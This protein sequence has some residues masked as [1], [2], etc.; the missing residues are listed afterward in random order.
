MV[1]EKPSDWIVH[2]CIK[3]SPD[4]L[5]VT[6]KRKRDSDLAPFAPFP[7]S[8]VQFML[9]TSPALKR[10]YSLISSV[11]KDQPEFIVKDVKGGK[12]SQYFHQQLKRGD[13][14]QIQGVHNSLWKDD[15]S[16]PGKT[17]ICFSGGIGVTPVYSLLHWGLVTAS[18]LN[19]SF[20]LFHSAKTP[21][22][23]LLT[24]ELNQ[25]QPNKRFNLMRVFSER[26][27][28][29]GDALGH[30]TK[31]NVLAWLEGHP[32]AHEAEFIICGPFG[33]MQNVHDA[34]DSL[35]VPAARRHTEYF[36]DRIIE[37]KLTRT[38]DAPVTCQDRPKCTV[39]IEQDSGVQQFKMH[40]EG[41]SILRAALQA[42][43]DVPHS[44][45]GGVCRS[46][47]AR[48]IE[49]EVL[50]DGVSGLSDSEK[51]E[52]KILCCRTQPKTNFLKL[53]FDH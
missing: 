39:E 4:S 25:L 6:L 14:L 7:G 38:T 10:Q 11:N 45:R 13:S 15:W 20:Q 5:R 35:E 3:A 12:A 44:C 31:E 40:G 34:L 1:Q 17:F 27:N 2:N 36:T 22:H 23:A 24:D 19:H 43:L 47:E 53:R 41:K 32:K 51:A 26:A 37:S 48:V 28:D 9:P 29:D 33:M 21:R 52:G 16:N 46:C 8:S 49:G 18:R 42:G 50:R 30:I